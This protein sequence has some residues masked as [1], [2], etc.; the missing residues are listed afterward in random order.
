MY[1]L[2]SSRTPNGFKPTIMLEELKQPYQIA[3]I[4]I[5][6]G[7]QFAPDFLK[8]SP[9]NKIPALYDSE[10]DFYLFESVA[11]LEYLAEKHQQFLPTELKAKYNVLK[12]CY[13]QA[14]H[15]GP[16][17]GQYGHFHRYAKEDVPY[18][19]KR[20]ADELLRLMGVMDNQ[21]ANNEFISGSDYTIADMAIWPWIYCYE[22]YYQ[23]KLDKK[24]FPHLVRWYH[25][26]AKRKAIKA[27]LAA[28]PV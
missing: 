2:Y 19:K 14:A 23:G 10:N 25:Q 28:Y 22:D 17:F 6:N 7:E 21:L 26:L 13:F 12:W 15:I 9:N 11:I 20:Y 27:T 24:H 8:I 3:L 16:M 5:F 1:K 4:D 18:A